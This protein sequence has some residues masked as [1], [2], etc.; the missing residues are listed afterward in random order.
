MLLLVIKCTVAAAV[1]WLLANDLL[2]L[3]MPAFAPFSAVLM[4]QTTVSQSMMQSVRYVVA[5]VSGVVATGVIG[6]LL[7]PHLWSLAVI[8]LLTLVIGRWRRL[9]SQGSQ[10]V[11]A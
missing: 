2:A 10:V 9:G 5:I 3:Q 7:G 6:S 1:A 4:I 8:A 11:T